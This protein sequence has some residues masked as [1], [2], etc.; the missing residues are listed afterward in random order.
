[1][2]PCRP[3]AAKVE[4]GAVNRIGEADVS[5]PIK[6]F[7]IGLL[8]LAGAYLLFFGGSENKEL[9]SKKVTLE[10]ETPQG[11]LRGSSVFDLTH[12]HAPWWYPSAVTGA[13]GIRGEAPYVDLGGGRYV[14]MLLQDDYGL[15]KT[16]QQYLIRER[17]AGSKNSRYG[18]T[19]ILVTFD[20]IEDATSVREVD[21]NVPSRTLGP[22]YGPVSMTLEDTRARATQGTLA[23]KFPALHA[24]LTA[25]PPPQP[26]AKYPWEV[27]REKKAREASGDTSPLPAPQKSKSAR[28]NV[29]RI[30]W[31]AFAQPMQ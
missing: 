25:T 10:I 1:M 20:N 13:F 7:L 14:F 30:S 17:E 4:S 19:P 29:P 5:W 3:P 18:D 27:E 31:G 26:R 16:I 15:S 22:G 9:G 23:K 8:L 24:A 21:R 12:S 28:P 2:S 6:R 11:L